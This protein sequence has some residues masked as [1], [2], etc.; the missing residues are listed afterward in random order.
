MN[1][2][3]YLT[4]NSLDERIAALCRHVLVREADGLPV[5]SV[6]QR[7]VDLGHNICVG[8]IGRSWM[9][10]YRQL[11]AGLEVIQTETVVIAEHDCLYT[12]EHLSWT[13]PDPGVFWYNENH[14][15]VNWHGNHPEMEGMY[16]Y[17]PKRTALSQLVCSPQLLEASTKEVMNL[18]FW[19]ILNKQ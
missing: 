3:L 16:S 14:W 10:L 15:L 5:V 7:P 2:I 11:L 8:E 6:S 4:D 13:P 1:T 17:W 9:S 18:F 12:H 19:K